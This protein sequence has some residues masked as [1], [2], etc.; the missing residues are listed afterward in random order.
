METSK[1]T[2]G[3]G[4]ISKEETNPLLNTRILQEHYNQQRHW[5]THFKTLI[6]PA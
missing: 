4:C 1:E 5:S 3:S 2:V 6:V